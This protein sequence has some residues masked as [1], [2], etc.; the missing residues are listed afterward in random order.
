M[1]NDEEFQETLILDHI[2]FFYPDTIVPRFEQDTFSFKFVPL[3][4]VNVVPDFPDEDVDQPAELI[5][6]K[7]K[8]TNQYFGF[9]IDIVTNRITHVQILISGDGYSVGP[10]VNKKETVWAEKK[11]IFTNNIE[12]FTYFFGYKKYT[13]LIRGDDFREYCMYDL[14]VSEELCSQI[15]RCLGIIENV[16]LIST[17]AVKEP[18]TTFVPKELDID[19]EFYEAQPQPVSETTKNSFC[20][21]VSNIESYLDRCLNNVGNQQNQVFCDTASGLPA[22][23]VSCTVSIKDPGGKT[24][25]QEVENSKQV[26]SENKDGF[27]CKFFQ[28]IIKCKQTQNKI[29][30]NVVIYF[31]DTFKGNQDMVPVEQDKS[32]CNAIQSPN[33]IDEDDLQCFEKA[34]NVVGFDFFQDSQCVDENGGQNPL[35]FKLIS[36]AGINDCKTL[37]GLE[38]DFKCEGF[39]FNGQ[40]NANNNCQLWKIPP[41]SQKIAKGSTCGRFVESV[42]YQEKNPRRQAYDQIHDNADFLY[43]TLILG[44]VIAIGFRFFRNN[45]PL[46][47][48]IKQI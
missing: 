23:C 41:F 36:V 21:S 48:L 40:T 20:S 39:S 46:Y 13:D 8:F 31:Y 44:I 6:N 28:V 26:C 19:R 38:R 32:V 24:M 10:L 34:F 43:P 15:P 45:D 17:D 9:I 25:E 12:F 16:C 1:A 5:L 7:Y 42:T 22:A 29:P 2:Y 47:Q 14:E 27:T 30:K 3:Q 37:C 4:P 11:P 35:N 18:L 33:T